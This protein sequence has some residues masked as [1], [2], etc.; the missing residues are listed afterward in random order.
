M[1]FKLQI[2]VLNMFH[3]KGTEFNLDGQKINQVVT[4]KGEDISIITSENSHYIG[5]LPHTLRLI[6]NY[7]LMFSTALDRDTE[8]FKFMN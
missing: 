4:N 8:S 5:G 1:Q 6:R 3:N 7:C 2:S